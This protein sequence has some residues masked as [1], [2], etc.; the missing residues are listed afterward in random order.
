MSSDYICSTNNESLSGTT[1]SP[2]S[3]TA[4]NEPTQPGECNAPVLAHTADYEEKNYIYRMFNF[5]DK[6]REVPGIVD[7]IASIGIKSHPQQCRWLL[8][9]HLIVQLD[10]WR[11]FPTTVPDKK[12]LAISQILDKVISRLLGDNIVDVSYFS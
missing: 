6:H 1:E 8:V 4:G 7:I 2:G 10:K 5:A 3:R 12:R 11:V 9:L